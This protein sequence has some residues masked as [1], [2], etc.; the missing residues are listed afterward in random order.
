MDFILKDAARDVLIASIH[1]A[2]AGD[3]VRRSQMLRRV[4][5][6]LRS[7]SMPLNGESR[8]TVRETQ[9]LRHLALGLSNKEIGRSLSI[10][11]ETVKEHVQNILRTRSR[12]STVRRQPF[13]RLRESLVQ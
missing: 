11:V 13:G 10:S 1:A 12:S 5:S 6:V 4:A 2:A 9:V 8:L 7:T 3:Q